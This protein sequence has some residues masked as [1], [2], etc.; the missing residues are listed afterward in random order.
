MTIDTT[1]RKLN[2]MHMSTMAECFMEQMSSIEYQ[3]LSFEERFTLMVDREW[4]NRQSNRLK[5]LIKSAGFR[6]QG[7]CI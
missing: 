2:E 4:D 1:V 6:D 5:R 3:Q 7:A